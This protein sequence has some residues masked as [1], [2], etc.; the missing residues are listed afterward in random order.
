MGE[1]VVKCKV[2]IAL[3]CIDAREPMVSERPRAWETWWS[4]S[5]QGLDHFAD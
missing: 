5:K 3:W 1:R 4:F 2:V